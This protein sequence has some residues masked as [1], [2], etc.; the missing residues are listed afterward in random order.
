MNGGDTSASTAERGEQIA[1]RNDEAG[2]QH[3]ERNA[4]QHRAEPSR[5]R[6]RSGC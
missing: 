6:R 3:G 5:R 4:E 1:P 2:G